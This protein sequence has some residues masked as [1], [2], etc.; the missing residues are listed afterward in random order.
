[1]CSLFFSESNS[2]LGGRGMY[3]NGLN[4]YNQP[5]RKV[6]NSTP[7]APKPVNLKSKKAESGMDTSVAI[8]KFQGSHWGGSVNPEVLLDQSYGTFSLVSFS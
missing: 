5:A 6:I 4:S 8:I 2:F 1:M 7:S 3:S